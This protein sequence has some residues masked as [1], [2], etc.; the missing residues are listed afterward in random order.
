MDYDK[1]ILI[2][3]KNMHDINLD[4][5]DKKTKMVI[6][7]SKT[8]NK[9]PINLVQRI[10]PFG[11]SIEWMQINKNEKKNAMKIFIGYFL[12]HYI[13]SQG[14]KQFRVYSDDR[15]Y[16]SLIEYLKSKNINAE[17][18]AS[19]KQIKNKNSFVH[20]LLDHILMFS[21][22][23]TTIQK[24]SFAVIAFAFVSGIIALL[25]A[26]A[27]APVIGTPIRDEAVRARIVSRINQEGI[28]TSVAADGLVQ[29][30]DENTARRARAILIQE[31][32][33][34]TGTDPW[35]IF[36]RERWTI[37]D[38][39][40]NVNARREQ[41]RMLTDLIKAID[42]IDDVNIVIVYPERKLFASDQN[43]VTVSVVITPKPGSDITKNLKKIEG[44][45]KIFKFTIEDLK[46][47]NIIIFDQSGMILNDFELIDE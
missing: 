39:E 16:D 17:R 14:N 46:D 11:N 5:I 34:P 30:A 10:Q 43:P 33:I 12:G 26:P 45:Q 15:D 31:D 37:T 32:L 25:P 38:F 4:S 42:D 2:D 41:T 18:M 27:M 47:E 21:N 8:K 9:L 7:F 3:C 24:I 22:K 1:Y 28:K 23:W 35:E 19:A 40:R 29:V 6:I 36:D 44:I 20:K 13:S